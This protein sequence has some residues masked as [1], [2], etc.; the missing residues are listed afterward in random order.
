MGAARPLLPPYTF[1]AWKVTTSVLPTFLLLMFLLP[2]VLS[3]KQP[4]KRPS[5]HTGWGSVQ[6]PPALAHNVPIFTLG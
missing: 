1:N 4:F 3:F 2:L 6:I 5:V